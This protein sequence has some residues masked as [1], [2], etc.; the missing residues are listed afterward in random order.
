[1]LKES[2]GKVVGIAAD[3]HVHRISNVLG[4]VKTKDPNKTMVALED[5]FPYSYWAE[6]DTVV[7][8]FAPIV[9]KNLF[10][11]LGENF[12]P[13]PGSFPTKKTRWLSLDRASAGPES[14]SAS[15]ASSTTN[16]ALAKNLKHW[17]APQ[18]FKIKPQFK[19]IL[20]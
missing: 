11:S 15:L 8:F 1:M 19:H 9:G 18:K 2:F 7:I 10:P 4:W 14:R 17:K 6:L 13:L 5:L 12:Q 16:A 3:T 20:T